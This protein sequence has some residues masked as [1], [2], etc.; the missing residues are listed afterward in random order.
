MYY[1]ELDGHAVSA[2]GVRSRKLSKILRALEGTLSRWSRLHLQSLAPPPGRRPVVKINAKSQHY[3]K[4]VAPTPLSE[5]R[6]GKRK[7]R[8][9]QSVNIKS[10][11]K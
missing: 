3:E 5:I 9:K 6:V 1:E 10:V 8:C 4:H 11:H 2:F 7:K